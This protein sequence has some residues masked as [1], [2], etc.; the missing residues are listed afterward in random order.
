MRLL[1]FLLVTIAIGACG[2]PKVWV[3]PGA[4]RVQAQKDYAWCYALGKQ[5]VGYIPDEWIQTAPLVKMDT[6]NKCMRGRGYSLQPA[7]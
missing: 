6:I 4:D 2:P 1:S 3:K 7:S 5:E